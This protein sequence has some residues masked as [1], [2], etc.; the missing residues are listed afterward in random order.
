MLEKYQKRDE[1]E[2]SSFNRLCSES[3]LVRGDRTQ[4]MRK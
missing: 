3:Q 1:E 4:M 2:S